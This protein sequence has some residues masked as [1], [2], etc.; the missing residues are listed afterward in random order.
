MLDEDA[1]KS[2]LKHMLGRDRAS[3]TSYANLIYA[4]MAKIPSHCK[5]E[6]FKLDLLPYVSKCDI[7]DRPVGD[8]W[9]PE[10]NCSGCL[11][12]LEDVI[13]RA[14]AN[15]ALHKDRGFCCLALEA[16]PYRRG[17]LGPDLEG[18]R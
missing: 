10:N 4:G 18:L 8:H 15:Y 7:C 6:E 12:L 11:E 2:F 16:L 9:I 14:Q 3:L 5:P 1:G 13:L 17:W